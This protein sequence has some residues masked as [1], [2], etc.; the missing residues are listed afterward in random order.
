M[1]DPTEPA[2]PRAVLA[3]YLNALTAGDLDA[4][5]DSFADDATWT[6]HGTLPMAGTKRGRDAIMDFLIGASSLYQPGTQSF[7]F[8]DITAEGE[9]VVLEWHVRGTATATGHTYDNDYCGV[10]IIRNGRITEVREY[11]DTLH[12][13]EVLFQPGEPPQY[14]AVSRSG[15]G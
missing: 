13:A 14:N 8:G 3:A 7:S 5:A 6:L 11:L 2:A 4:I 10:F 9:R 15:R 12:A 1:T